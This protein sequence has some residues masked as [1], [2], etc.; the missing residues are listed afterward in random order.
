[1]T[2]AHMATALR[3]AAERPL[4]VRHINASIPDPVDAAALPAALDAPDGA[5]PPDLYAFFDEVEVET[6]S[7]LARSGAVGYAALAQGARRCLPP[8]DATRLRLDE[9]A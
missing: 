7:D 2:A 9:R 4:A 5:C 6:L 8:D 1:M 3:R